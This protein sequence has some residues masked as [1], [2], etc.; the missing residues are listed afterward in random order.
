MFDDSMQE[1]QWE[2]NVKRW[3]VKAARV[4]AEIDC[5][6]ITERALIQSGLEPS[7]AELIFNKYRPVILG[8][9]D[10]FRE[11]GEDMEEWGAIVGDRVQAR[12][13]Q[14]RGEGP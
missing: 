13:E 12:R 2:H 14:Q 1:Q 11:V 10:A 6:E 9:A 4:E 3:V 7:M 8:M 5:L